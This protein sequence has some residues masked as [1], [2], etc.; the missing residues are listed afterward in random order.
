MSPRTPLALFVY[1]RPDHTRRALEAIARLQRRDEVDLIIFSDAPKRP[2]HGPAVQ[3]VRDLVHG[4]A[5]KGRTTVV[6]RAENFGLA[7]SIAGA[8]STLTED[9]GRVVVLED[10]L[11]PTPDFLPFMLDGLDRYADQPTVLQIAGCLLPGSLD[12]REDGFFLPLTTTWGWATWA[13]AWSGFA[14]IGPQERA[15]LDTDVD[16]RQRFTADGAVDYVAMLDDRLAGRNDSWGILWWYTV[17]KARGL[18]LYP[19]ES[20]IWNGGFDA[21]GVHCGGTEVFQPRAPERFNHPRLPH[22]ISLPDRVEPDRRAWVDLLRFLRSGAPH[23]ERR[24]WRSLVD[25]LLPRS[26]AAS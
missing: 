5:G 19:R 3:E 23:I 1:N 25:R 4:S 18:V 16:F 26:R 2:E 15:A 24:G 10:D 11:V 7:R 12:A 21:S 20:L 13:R 9:H 14:P 17:A 8:V 22:P 6:E